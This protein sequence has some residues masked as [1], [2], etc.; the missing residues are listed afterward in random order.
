MTFRRLQSAPAR[1][2]MIREWI[3]I[4]FLSSSSSSEFVVDPSSLGFS[5][6][7]GSSHG[8]EGDAS[9]TGGSSVVTGQQQQH[10]YRRRRRRES[11]SSGV[12]PR[13]VIQAMLSPLLAASVLTLE[14]PMTESMLFMETLWRECWSEMTTWCGDEEDGEDLDFREGQQ[15]Y[16]EAL[17]WLTRALNMY[18]LGLPCYLAGV[19]SNNKSSYY[20]SASDQLAASKEL[21]MRWLLQLLELASFL[22]QTFQDVNGIE[23]HPRDPLF[24]SIPADR[25]IQEAVAHWLSQIAAETVPR[26]FSVLPSYQVPLEPILIQILQ[27]LQRLS[28]QYY[29]PLHRHDP[30]TS[31]SNSIDFL[32]TVATLR[33]ASVVL[34][35]PLPSDVQILLQ[36]LHVATTTTI[37][38][39]PTGSESTASATSLAMLRGLA[40]M[41]MR[42][43][44]C[45][46]TCQELIHALNSVQTNNGMLS[47]QPSMSSMRK[48]STLKKVKPTNRSS[49]ERVENVIQ[50]L[51]HSIIDVENFVAFLV[52]E[53]CL[54]GTQCSAMQQTG[55]LLFGIALLMGDDSKHQATAYTFL[56]HLL[57]VYPHLGISLLPVLV[58]CINA[59]CVKGDAVTLQRQLEFLSEAVVQDTQ[60]AREIWNLLGVQLMKTETTPSVIRASIIR[61]FPKLC[62]AN[63]RLYKRVMEALGDQLA[64]SSHNVEIRLA[65]AA[66]IAELAKEDRIRDVTDVIGWI[67]GFITEISWIRPVSTL[68]AEKSGSNA[69]LVHYAVLALHYLLV[70]QE[71]D[72]NLVI[73]VINKRLCNVH[74]VQEVTMLPPLVL[75]SLVLLLGDGECDDDD[76]ED[77]EEERALQS[78]V[79]S[80]QVSKSVE[81]LV[82][83]ALS[84]KLHTKKANRDMILKGTLLRCRRNIQQ[85]LSQYSV[86]ALGIDDVG[87]QA[88]VSAAGADE[89][90]VL[91]PSGQRYESLR[92]VVKDGVQLLENGSYKMN[93]VGAGSG[94]DAP[95]SPDEVAESDISASLG[96]LISKLLKFEED[97]LGSTLWQKKGSRKGPSTANGKARVQGQVSADP[98]QTVALPTSSNVQKIYNDSRS[99]GNALGVL[100]CFEG[101]PLSFFGDLAADITHESSDPFFRAFTVQAWLNAARS[102]LMELVMSFSSSEGLESVLMDVREWRF[103]LDCPDNMYLALSSLALM[104]PDILGPYGDHSPYV[105][106]ICE[107]VWNGYSDTEFENEDIAKLSIGL[108]GVCALRNGSNELLGDIIDALERSVSGYGGQASF[109]AYYGLSIIAQSCQHSVNGQDDGDDRSPFVVG[110]VS[111]I[112]GFLLNELIACIS[113]KHSALASLT[114]CIKGGN[115]GP[116]VIDQMTTLGTKSLKMVKARKEVAKSLFIG[117]AICLPALAVVN[118]ELLL[119]VYCLLEAIPWGYGKGIALASVL[120]ECK[121]TGLF[122][123]R[124]IEKIYE[125]Y[126]QIFENGM[127]KGLS[128]LDDIFCAV[129]ATMTKAIPDSIRRFLVGNRTLFDEDGRAV[130]LLATVVSISSVP[131]LGCGSSTFTENPQLSPR[132]KSED[133]DGVKTLINEAVAS[134]EPDKYSQIGV[135]LMGFLASMNNFAETGE[136]SIHSHSSLKDRLQNVNSVLPTA[137]QGTILEV[138]MT[139]LSQQFYEPSLETNESSTNLLVKLLGCLE[140]LSLPAQLAAFLEQTFRGN[141]ETKTACT[142]L[143]MSQIRGRPRAVFDGR[144]YIDLALKIS[145][146]PPTNIKTLLGQGEA[147]ILFIEALV[148]LVPKFSTDTVGEVVENFWRLCFNQVGNPGMSVAFLKAMKALVKGA[149]DKKSFLISPKT[150]TFFRHFLVTRAFAGIRDAPWTSTSS[151]ST[152]EERS[153]VEKYADCL[154]EIPVST[155]VDTEFFTLKELDGFPGEALRYRCVMVLVRKGYFTTPSRASSEIASAIAWFSRQL[156][157]SEEEVFSST[158][159]QVAC[160]IAD[161]TAAENSD[162]R[163]EL[164]LTLLDNLLLT[165]PSASYVGLQMLGV[166]VCRWVNGEGSDGDLSLACLIST[167][168]DRWKELS[169]P[170]L[171]QTFRILVHDLPANLAT[172]IRAERMSSVVFN[173]LCRVY[174]KWFEQG[175][176]QETMD[177]VRK[178]LICCRTV[179]SGSDDFASLATLMLKT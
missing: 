169:P 93:P 74:D 87:L 60:C 83:L 3:Q 66:T 134:R 17:E 41:L 21:A 111:R 171:Q 119:G 59:A 173:R 177:C 133:I 56:G 46:T 116:E 54:V 142:K 14:N 10:H 166:L 126:A 20:S 129:T 92:Q 63:K 13:Q 6:S 150:L 33:L 156:T 64:T 36:I 42:K 72:F 95:Y 91:P 82:S 162:S 139:A 32:S 23:H 170:S 50:F 145:K 88:L 43:E 115:I 51:D 4:A 146:L 158:L 148:D 178:A 57:E 12:S 85:S 40:S 118:D 109:G 2:M 8:E 141:D 35:N 19:G 75:E 77:E 22:V 47:H 128:G 5:G 24:P 34:S 68:D 168:M 157:S 179:D 70:A 65:V 147:P 100:L 104:I 79:V 27:I 89:P 9:V 101:K 144:D 102:T 28:N 26:L 58:D 107:E 155:L 71:L 80:S 48:Y 130:S 137:Q 174:N 149:D 96:S 151:S 97:I 121:R 123:S 53:N 11:S 125:K 152:I 113:G 38:T 29:F 90:T 114:G 105:N 86:E 62:L 7:H 117:L 25:A 52:K 160:S 37:V 159:L 1:M 110:L 120:Q 176:E 76:E 94:K 172:Y 81:T 140:V 127:E 161:A 143:L 103:R 44:G 18:L 55:T 84:P 67:Q 167:Q 112:V 73:V 154:L 69:A 106:E 153:I 31:K 131:C 30:K 136:R 99:S 61:L 135:L 98:S 16:L 124:E 108:I 49:S 175:A 163:K 45:Q 78:T 39:S 132:A 165:G 122:K 138:V 164:L 15:D